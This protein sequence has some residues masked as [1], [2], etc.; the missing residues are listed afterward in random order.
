KKPI[1]DTE[2]T[3]PYGIEFDFQNLAQLIGT[4]RPE[5][6][7]FVDTID[8]LRSEFAT[9]GL[10]PAA[11]H[12][13]GQRGAKVSAIVTVFSRAGETKSRLHERTHFPR[14][15]IACHENHGFGEIHPS[16]VA[17]R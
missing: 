7:H 1:R 3:L 9:R 17:K 4:Q 14:A 5:Y 13:T 2:Y 15:D 6:N 8:E 10:K 11:R 12:F 16:V